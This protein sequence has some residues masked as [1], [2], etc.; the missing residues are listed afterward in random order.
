MAQKAKEKNTTAKKSGK[1]RVDNTVKNPNEQPEKIAKLMRSFGI[2]EICAAEFSRRVAAAEESL[3][4]F[5][6]V[7]AGLLE[8][9]SAMRNLKFG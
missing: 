8:F 1:S 5:P 4:K 6:A 7:N 3:G 2:P 9:C